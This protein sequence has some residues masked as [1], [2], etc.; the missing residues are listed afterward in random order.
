MTNEQEE[1]KY[2]VTALQEE[3]KKHP[4]SVAAFLS[5]ILMSYSCAINNWDQH[6]LVHLKVEEARLS[7]YTQELCYTH[8]IQRK[9]QSPV[10]GLNKKSE[11]LHQAVISIAAAAQADGGG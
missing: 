6:N 10:C 8:Q 7:N 9:I 5:I 1:Y 2:A 3:E 4:P 11:R